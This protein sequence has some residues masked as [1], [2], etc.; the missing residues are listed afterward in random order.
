ML[1]WNSLVAAQDAS[2]FCEAW[3]ALQC[4]MIAGTVSG[5][6]LLDDGEDH[7]SSVAGWPDPR[8]DLSYL[9][10]AAQQALAQQ[11]TFVAWDPDRGVSKS[12][13]IGQPLAWSGRL[14]GVVVVDLSASA[15]DINAAIKQ[16]RW[17][18]AWLEVLFARQQ[19]EQD[20]AFTSRTRFAL[21][22]LTRAQAQSSFQ[23]SALAVVNELAARLHCSRVGIGLWDG[24]TIRL[25]AIS[26][27]AVFSEKTH[28]V[29]AIENAM[30]ETADQ[31]AS[32]VVPPL[33]ST[34]RR[35]A[36]A[37]EDLARRS[38]AASIASVVMS[39]SSGCSGVILLER[40]SH[41]AFDA[42]TLELIEAVGALVGP[43][44]RTKAD[45]DR[46]LTGRAIRSATSGLKALLGP[47]RP[48]LK[49]TAAAIAG[50]LVYLAVADGDFR[51]TA[52]AV[53]EG[54]VQRAS[55]A[56]FDGYIVTASTRA[57]DIVEEGQV[58]A[59]LDDRELR[60]EAAR[61][62][63][64]QSQQMLKYNDA[65]A[66]H[67]RATALVTSAALDQAQ[68]Q[69]TLTEDKIARAVIRAPFRGV[70][71]SGDLSQMIGSPI[72]KGKVMFEVAPLA[73]YRVILQVDERDI[74]LLAD[75]QTG[76]LVLTGLATDQTRI[77][78]KK[79]TPVATAS[80]GRNYFRVEADV[81]GADQKLRP[82]MEGIGKIDVDRR[83]LLAIWTRPLVDWARIS[84]WKWLP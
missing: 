17:G 21:D 35:I 1:L 78:V 11:T 37:H 63:S 54:G 8:R 32:I 31:S 84:L 49:V 30:E 53:V 76:T 69:L 62:K 3:L 61:W 41:D 66:K 23:A 64:E 27:T 56:P 82:G 80:E 5:L 60:L 51:I 58:M 7:F 15:I 19:L 72:E 10:N 47:G 36:L 46:W 50:V 26:H 75:G 43:E 25:R 38:G 4:G 67:D 83:S 57:G 42:A 52:K 34:T 18:T 28:I 22:V 59:A 70:V 68:A 9:T 40:D 77:A 6:L 33:S 48:T 16:L 2:A 44:L 12:V 39:G 13:H 79:I 24:R 45:A 74:T 81:Q 20:G 73:S 65:L 71:I 55:V 29:S 14:K